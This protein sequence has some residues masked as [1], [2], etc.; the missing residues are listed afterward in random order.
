VLLSPAA[1]GTAGG[2]A[3][4]SEAAAAVS[5][6]KD[7]AAAA[8]AAEAAAGSNSSSSSSKKQQQYLLV[9]AHHTAVLDLLLVPA[10]TLQLPPVDEESLSHQLQAALGSMQELLSGPLGQPHGN[11]MYKVQGLPK[12]PVELCAPLHCLLAEAAA[13]ATD[14]ILLLHGVLLDMQIMQDV[15]FG[16]SHG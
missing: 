13:L 1:Q 7:V 4:Q 5:T 14:R 10:D 11:G 9:P 6:S 3:D 2:V 12:V 15:C 8:A 16:V